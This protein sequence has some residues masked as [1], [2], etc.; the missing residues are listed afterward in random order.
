MTQS[1]SSP[2]GVP[3]GKSATRQLEEDFG[4]DIPMVL[5]VLDVFIETVPDLLAKL[6]AA[7]DQSDISAAGRVSHSL[8][9]AL[10]QVQAEIPR[11][12]AFEIEQACK[13]GDLKAA[14]APVPELEKTVTDLLREMG[15]YK[16]RNG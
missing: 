7:L 13:T 5:M 4:G 10:A 9:G 3:D 16:L 2:Q 11:D 8:K 14:A 12:L 15:I 1:E 6:K